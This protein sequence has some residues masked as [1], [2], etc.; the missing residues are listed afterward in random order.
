[1]DAIAVLTAT[2]LGQLRTHA[3]D[4]PALGA[5]LAIDR[6]AATKLL[7]AP[8][9]TFLV[10]RQP[11]DRVWLV[12][13]LWSLG[14]RHR[15]KGWDPHPNNAPIIDIT[16]IVGLLA[17]LEARRLTPAQSEV[18]RHVVSDRA[19]TRKPF[20]ARVPK[21]MLKALGSP[22]PARPAIPP[23]PAPKLPKRMELVA[24]LVSAQLEEVADEL[25][26]NPKRFLARKNAF[27]QSVQS[28]FEGSGDEAR[29]LAHELAPW[30]TAKVVDAAAK[31]A[32]EDICRGIVALAQDRARDVPEPC[33]S[34]R[35]LLDA[36][37]PWM[38]DLLG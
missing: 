12:A 4:E 32:I 33:A 29:L 22:K 30:K 15:T 3:G 8:G 24:Q 13:R 7:D 6:H 2:E 36:Y 23:M 31:R 25:R 26:D 34:Y 38:R 9:A 11:G 14:E 18:L 28:I 16:S 5:T 27:T 19:S 21:S 1:M 35:A 20:A 17:P 10:A 37:V